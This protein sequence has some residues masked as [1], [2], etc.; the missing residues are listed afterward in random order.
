[1]EGC[2]KRSRGDE[3]E[4]NPL[5]AASDEPLSS[6]QK[7][8]NWQFLISSCSRCRKGITRASDSSSDSISCKI[9]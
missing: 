8:V 2:D 6:F 5:W 3:A 1:V 4:R 9:A 7:A